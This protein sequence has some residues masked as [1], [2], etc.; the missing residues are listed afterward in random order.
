MKQIVKQEKFIFETL[1]NSATNAQQ[2]IEELEYGK[3]HEFLEVCQDR[4]KA[5]QVYS[6]FADMVHEEA[7]LILPNNKALRREYNMGILQKLVDAAAKN[8]ASI[9]IL[10]PLDEDNQSIVKW[11]SEYGGTSIQILDSDDSDSTIFLVDGKLLFRAEFKIENMEKFPDAIGYAVYSNSKPTVNSFKSLFEMLWNSRLI[12]EKLLQE[13]RQQREFIHIAAYEL[14]TPIQPILG[15][16]ELIESA[17][18]E[19]DGSSLAVEPEEIEMIARNARRL[20][21]LSEDILDIAR[22]ESNSLTLNKSTFNLDYVI[23]TL[24]E[25]CRKQIEMDGRDVSVIIINEHAADVEVNADK[26]RIMQ[27]LGN[28]LS[29]AL[30][31]TQKGAITIE[32]LLLQQQHEGKNNQVSIKVSGTGP[33][34]DKELLPRLFTKFVTKSERGTGLGLYISKSII[35]V[36]GGRIWA[37]NNAD[38]KGATF[39]CTLLVCGSSQDNKE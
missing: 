30:K 9:R 33:G 36:H 14:R 2:R 16:A 26:Q 13:D 34:V 24:A 5:A 31:F 29:N 8:K 32:V 17:I 38:G 1:W 15:M 10:C 11:L 7:L 23:K 4:L 37:E 3:E 18:Q 19:K 12:A 27:V 22:I 25:D 21:K 20:Y 39:T 28:L 6:D 35:E